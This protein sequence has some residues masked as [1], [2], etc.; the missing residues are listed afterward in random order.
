MHQKTATEIVSSRMAG[1]AREVGEA[2]GRL[3]LLRNVLT[4]P[5]M[6]IVLVLSRSLNVCAAA[7]F[8]YG[9]FLISNPTIRLLANAIPREGRERLLARQHRTLFADSTDDVADRERVEGDRTLT[10]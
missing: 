6:A 5:G 1:K 4:I 8:A 2:L 9:A 7:L 10:S 3:T